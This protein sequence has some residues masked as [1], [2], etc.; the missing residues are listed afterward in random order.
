MCDQ[1]EITTQIRKTLHLVVKMIQSL[2][3]R[4]HKSMVKLLSY[5]DVKYKE[6]RQYPY[7][8]GTT[9]DLDS[10]PET[11]HAALSTTGTQHQELKSIINL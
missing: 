2:V 4:G 9:I 1:K 7:N 8:H 6:T 3:G 11:A 5:K 10:I